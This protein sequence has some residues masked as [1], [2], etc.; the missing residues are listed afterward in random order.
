M[1]IKGNKEASYVANQ[2]LLFSDDVGMSDVSQRRLKNI[3]KRPK[4]SKYSKE[5]DVDD[6]YKIFKKWF[7]GRSDRVLA[8][9][10]INSNRQARK[11]RKDGTPKRRISISI[12]LHDELVKIK[13]QKGLESID[14]VITGCLKRLRELQKKIKK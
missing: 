5:S 9:K 1:F 14:D 10:I 11:V 12:K 3:Y 8:K 7:E 6:C 13:D 2:M 4:S